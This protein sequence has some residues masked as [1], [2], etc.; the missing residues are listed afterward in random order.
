[1]ED[2][3]VLRV[4]GKTGVFFFV[5]G[6]GARSTSTGPKSPLRPRDR[7]LGQLD[8]TIQSPGKLEKSEKYKTSFIV[9]WR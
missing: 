8:A 1:V 6:L 3:G 7:G 9:Y 2:G 4:A 5:R